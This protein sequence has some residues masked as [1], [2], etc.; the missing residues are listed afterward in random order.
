VSR[1]RR[2]ERRDRRHAVRHAVVV[3]ERRVER[4]GQGEAAERRAVVV[5]DRR[6]AADD[7]LAAGEEDE[8]EVDAVAVDALRRRVAW[9]V[10][11]RFDPELVRL[12]VPCPDG[13][14][15]A[16]EEAIAEAQDR[17]QAL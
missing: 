13:R 11:T 12:D 9:R 2:I 10:R 6:R 8:D 16:A 17:Q 7:V 1:T 4:L 5:V 15:E 14:R 3:D